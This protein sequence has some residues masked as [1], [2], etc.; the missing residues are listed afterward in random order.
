LDVGSTLAGVAADD[1]AGAVEVDV[2]VAAEGAGEDSADGDGE[3]AV[4]DAVDTG[5]AAPPPPP[6]HADIAPAMPRMEVN[7]RA[8]RKFG[9]NW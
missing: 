7:R 9:F 8:R 2:D 6:P 1:A 4:D 5:S 3:D